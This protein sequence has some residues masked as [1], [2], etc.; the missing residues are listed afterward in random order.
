MAPLRNFVK[1]RPGCK[2][3]AVRDRDRHRERSCHVLM[4]SQVRNEGLIAQFVAL[5]DDYVR[6]GCGDVSIAFHGTKVRHLPSIEEKGL[7]VS[8][9]E[10]VLSNFTLK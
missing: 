3:R 6:L 1:S 7:L 8:R 10:Y 5:R 9:Y 4:Y 2:V